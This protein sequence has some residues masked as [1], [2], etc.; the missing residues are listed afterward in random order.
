MLFYGILLYAKAFGCS[1]IIFLAF[2][3][4][5]K[6]HIFLKTHKDWYD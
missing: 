5:I 1:Y 4:H 6:T 2:S 3:N